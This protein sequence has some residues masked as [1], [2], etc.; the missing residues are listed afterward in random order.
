MKITILHLSE[1]RYGRNHKDRQL[2][3]L[4]AD[5]DILE[6]NENI[7]PNFIVLTGDISNN[8]IE[9]EYEIAEEALQCLIDHLCMNRR[10]V[11]MVPGD[12]DVNRK[13]CEA[14]RLEADAHGDF[15]NPPYYAKFKNYANFFYK[16]YENVQF[17][18]EVEPYRLDEEDTF[19]NFYFPDEGIVFVGLNSCF[20]ESE[21][22]PHYGNITLKQLEQAIS[23]MNKFGTDKKML[24]IA[25]M[26]H[27]YKQ[28]SRYKKDNLKD[29]NEL[30][31]LLLNN[32]FRFIFHGHQHFSYD[33]K[34]IKNGDKT[35]DIFETGTTG[36]DSD[37]EAEKS[38]RYQII[39]IQDNQVRI[40]RRCSDNL[41][42]HKYGRGCWK[43]DL[44]PDQKNWFDVYTLSAE[45]E[46]N[47][48]SQY[49]KLLQSNI[50]E[51]FKYKPNVIVLLYKQ[52]SL[53]K[54][55]IKDL[56][57]NLGE[58]YLLLDAT[59]QNI[60]DFKNLDN[61][62]YELADRLT[63]EFENWAN[64]KEISLESLELDKL[65]LNNFKGNGKTK[66]D[67]Y[68]DKIR[69]IAKGKHPVVIF[70][71]IGCLFNDSQNT[72]QKI[73]TFF[74]EFVRDPEKG[75]FILAG[76]EGIHE[77]GKHSIL[78]RRGACLNLDR[79]I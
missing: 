41:R 47:L 38:Y 4:K 3:K 77:Y 78:I 31:Y 29:A 24:R 51:Y 71:E 65:K 66:F 72:D 15:F 32:D 16:F 46:E 58:G 11:V 63:S 40:Y 54:D 64:G 18:K 36:L 5:L 56:S 19:V 17:P 25:L 60:S 7:K 67:E 6:K 21:K 79:S 30:T 33:N 26:H 14:A 9:K 23:N 44:A 2:K 68:W 12:H 73:L 42:M 70:N 20:D 39:N 69:K 37:I 55:F 61:F 53:L 50:K 28:L 76:P 45:R 57:N 35:I 52:H 48:Y 59:L 49:Q 75:S 8:S 27:N 34:V 22:K 10:Y 43:P 74:D 1:P 62:A 13:L